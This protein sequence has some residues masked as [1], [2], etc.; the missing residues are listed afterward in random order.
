MTE[1]VVDTNI[2]FST[3]INP[4]GSVGDLLLKSGDCLSFIAPQFLE[5]EIEKHYDRLSQLTGLPLT[6]LD[7]ALTIIL[8]KITYIEETQIPIPI[9]VESARW[10]REIDRMDVAFVAASKFMQKPLWTGDKVLTKGLRAWGYSLVLSTSQVLAL[11]EE[12]RS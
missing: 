10:L 9:W 6:D 12:L 7:E 11:R 8:A 1:L 2:V 3:L 5:K 4:L